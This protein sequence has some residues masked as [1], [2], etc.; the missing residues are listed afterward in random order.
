MTGSRLPDLLVPKPAVLLLMGLPQMRAIRLCAKIMAVVSLAVALL[1][2]P[3]YFG[4]AA[5][6]TS[7]RCADGST[8]YF[9]YCPGDPECFGPTAT[10]IRFE[11]ASVSPMDNVA[12]PERIRGLHNGGITCL[13]IILFTSDPVLADRRFTTI[14]SAFAD[15]NFFPQFVQKTVQEPGEGAAV[16]GNVAIIYGTQRTQQ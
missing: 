4:P 1:T 5:A 9:G 14:V 15:A 12:P 2:A 11:G 8:A 3:S 13:R 6:Q 10:I 16:E 7:G